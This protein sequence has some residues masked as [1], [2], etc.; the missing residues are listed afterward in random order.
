MAT[1]YRRNKKRHLAPNLESQ[2]AYIKH[3]FKYDLGRNVLVESSD[4]FAKVGYLD[5]LL[6]YS[7]RIGMAGVKKE[8]APNVTYAYWCFNFSRNR[9]YVY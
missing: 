9:T 8:K 6:T 2:P 3:R 5:N 1:L 4:C 7:M